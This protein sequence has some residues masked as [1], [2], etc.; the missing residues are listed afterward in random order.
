MGEKLGFLKSQSKREDS[1]LSLSSC[2]FK[3]LAIM[4]ENLIYTQPRRSGLKSPLSWRF[5]SDCSL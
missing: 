5:M 3:I 1:L 2:K 4:V